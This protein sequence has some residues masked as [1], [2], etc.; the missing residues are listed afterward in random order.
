MKEFSFPLAVSALL[1][2]ATPAFAQDSAPA[3]AD[4]P[5][6]RVLAIGNSFSASLCSFLP[7]AAAAVLK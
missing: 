4:K 2:V 1:V 5:P 3:P 6:L 7:A